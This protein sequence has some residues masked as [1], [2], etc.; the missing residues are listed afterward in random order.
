[1]DAAIRLILKLIRLDHAIVHHRQHHRVG[2]NGSKLLHQIERQRRS[3]IFIGVKETIVSIQ[4]ATS[5][6]VNNAFVNN[7]YA[8]LN[9][10]FASSFGGRRVRFSNAN[11]SRSDFF[12]IAK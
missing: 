4:P 3:P 11:S 6:A 2:D 9:N 5:H 10:A 7:E 8:K 1:M 12:K